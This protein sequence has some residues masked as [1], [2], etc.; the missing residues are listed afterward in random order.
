[1]M[2]RAP[3][4]PA[5]RRLDEIFEKF[6]RE[7]TL[8]ERR[9]RHCASVGLR[10]PGLVGARAFLGAG[11]PCEPLWGLSRHSLSFEQ[12]G[13]EHRLRAS[14]TLVGRALEPAH[15][16]LVVFARARAMVM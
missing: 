1:R 10:N 7:C 16:L 6:A 3:T 2:M 9:L 8:V 13:A 5:R 12:H 11:E 4:L 15:G 14:Q